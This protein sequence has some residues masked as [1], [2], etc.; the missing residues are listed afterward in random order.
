MRIAWISSWPPRHCGIATYSQE[1]VS[2]LRGVGNEVHVVCHTGGGRPGER[3]VYPIINT[4]KVGWDEEMYRIVNQL[5]PEIVHI[6]HEYGLYNTYGDHAVCLFRP[7]FRWKIEQDFPVVITYHSV[8]TRLNK[9]MSTYMDA[10]QRLVDGGTVFAPYQWAYLT[11]N[12]GRMVDNIYVIS[13]GARADLQVDGKEARRKLG[14]EGKK[15]IG[16]MGW[17]TPSK[18][19]HYVLNRWDEISEALGAS[20]ILV[21]AGDARLADPSQLEYKDELLSLVKGSRFKNRIKVMLGSFTPEEYESILAAFDIMVM[22]YTLASQSGNLAHSFSLGI[23]VVASAMEGLK[24]ALDESGAGVG[25]PPGD[26]DEL[27][28]AILT[29]MT[30]DRLRLNCSLKAK[31]YVQEKI[32]WPAIVDKHM[33]LYRKMIK[34]KQTA[35]INLAEEAMLES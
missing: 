19:F 31:K 16:L 5:D 21:L 15:V 6:Q 9:M 33:R 26:D 12:L 23:P 14:L 28:Q 17:F 22:P 35:A 7:V 10:M 32:G 20:T 2:H 4:S 24:A 13:H 1:L 27:V 8:Y 30:D 34:K 3:D 29:L 11:A 18:G 25:C